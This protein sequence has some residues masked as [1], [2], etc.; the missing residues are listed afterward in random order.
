[1][2]LWKRGGGR[3]WQ[4]DQVTVHCG[5]QAPFVV[6]AEIAKAFNIPRGKCSVIVSD[7][8]SG[9]GAK[10]NSE[11]ELE[12]VRLARGTREPV[13]LAW[14]RHEEFT[15][16]YCRPAAVMEVRSGFQSRW[17]NSCLGVSQLQR[18]RCFARRSLSNSKPLCRLSRIRVTVASWFLPLS[19]G[20]REYLRS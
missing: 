3:R 1:M 19:R 9:Y 5:T 6:R 4:G 12:A 2:S 17:Q 10:H 14:S 8:G 13:R 18:R 16:S 15:Q 7:T 20:S 11:C